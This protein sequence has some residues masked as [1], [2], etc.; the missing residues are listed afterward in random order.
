MKYDGLRHLGAVAAQLRERAGN[1]RA[2]NGGPLPSL[3]LVTDTL[4]HPDPLRAMRCL[5][6]GSAVLLRDYE[7]AQRASLAAALAR[8]CSALGIALWVG[9][10]LALARSVAAD[11]LHLRERDVGLL[12]REQ[13]HGVL[14]TSVHSLGALERAS[15]L[16]PDAALIA[17]VFATR[18]HPDARP[19][20]VKRLREMVR[21]AEMP[22][23]ALGGINLSNASRLLD[24]GVAGVAAVDALHGAAR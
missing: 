10:D 5:P 18:T 24:T 4:R 8:E 6:R 16:A 13:W 20:G 3:I 2:A 7:H 22:V 14:T 11:G 21:E 12:S 17:P 9:A 1:P 15:R 19:I 23:Y